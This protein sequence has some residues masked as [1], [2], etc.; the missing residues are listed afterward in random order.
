MAKVLMKGNEAMAEAAIRAGCKAFFGYPITPQNEIPE[1]FSREL[2]KVNGFNVN[3]W[4][5]TCKI[6]KCCDFFAGWSNL[7]CVFPFLKS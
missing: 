7:P 4:G 2:P 5:W 3:C 6:K 1:Y